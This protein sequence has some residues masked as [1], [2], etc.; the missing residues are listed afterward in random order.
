MTRI[1]SS[2][3]PGISEEIPSFHLNYNAIQ[4]IQG[5]NCQRAELS[6]V[7]YM[8]ICV[9][10]TVSPDSPIRRHK[11]VAVSVTD[12]PSLPHTGLQSHNPHPGAVTEAQ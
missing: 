1:S 11:G 8:T 2:L 9:T 4:K 7:S 10:H 12:S 3:A 5:L 6:C